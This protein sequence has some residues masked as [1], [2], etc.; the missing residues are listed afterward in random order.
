MYKD[1]PPRIMIEEFLDNGFG[2]P[3]DDL[4]F[5]VFDGKVQFIQIDVDRFGAHRRNIYDVSSNLLPVR[6]TIQT[7]D[8][9]IERPALLNEM[10]RHAEALSGSVDFVQLELYVVGDEAVYFGE[11][12]PSS[13]SGFNSFHPASYDAVFGSFWKMRIL[14]SPHEP[15]S[16][17]VLP[18]HAS[19]S[20]A[21]PKWR[22]DRPLV[23]SGHAKTHVGVGADRSR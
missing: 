18:E 6:L 19:R 13:G 9:E 11:M 10:L 23:H 7:Y 4:K 12:T 14:G 17:T 2:M 8:G 5:H 3:P 21:P 1:V 15:P 22:R 16:R 20:K